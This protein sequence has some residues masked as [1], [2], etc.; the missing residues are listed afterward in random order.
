MTRMVAVEFV[1]YGTGRMTCTVAVSYAPHSWSTEQIALYL[2][3]Q[4]LIKFD[5]PYSRR[6]NLML[7]RD[8][9]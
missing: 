2:V 5:L 7:R 6:N 8:L 3:N 1:K 4:A 9:K